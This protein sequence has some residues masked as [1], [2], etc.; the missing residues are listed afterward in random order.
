MNKHIVSFFIILLS[1][2]LNV[3][4]QQWIE[5]EHSGLV[6]DSTWEAGYQDRLT[7]LVMNP[8]DDCTDRSSRGDTDS[9]KRYWPLLLCDMH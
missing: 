7:K 9:G 3:K 1:V 5:V 4:A 6:P 2:G 8:Y